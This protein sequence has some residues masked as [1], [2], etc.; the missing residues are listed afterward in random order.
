GGVPVKVDEWEFDAVYSGSQ[1]CLSCPPGL[2]P[3]TFSKS[4]LDFI[5]SRKSQVQSWFMDINLV[6]SYWG[7]SSKRSYHHTAPINALYGLHEALILLQEEGIEN[8]WTRHQKNSTIFI[9]GLKNLDLEVFVKEGHRL[10]ELAT[11]RIPDGVDDNEVRNR[12][13]N[14]FN[15]EI[16]AGLGVLAGKIWRI[17]LMG[18]TSNVKNIDTC[19]SALKQILEK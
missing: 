17:G 1:K 14:E 12:L 6:T 3:V 4:A 19:L 18:Y 15:I 9:E 10:P 16:G 13:L 2:S 11:I 5:K 7:S 8:A